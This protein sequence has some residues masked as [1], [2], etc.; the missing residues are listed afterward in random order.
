M[1]VRTGGKGPSGLSVLLVPLKNQKGVSMRKI[2]VSGGRA[3]GTTFIE[4]DDVE[5]PVGNILGKE[6]DGMKYIMVCWQEILAYHSS[7]LLFSQNNFNH[8]RLTIAALVGTQARVALSTAFEWVMKRE[9][10]GSPLINQAVV[11]HRLAKAGAE[12]ETLWAWIE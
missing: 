2:P 4:L 11:R 7:D 6:G 8:E 1:C 9:A 12:L 10:F 3:S 5:V